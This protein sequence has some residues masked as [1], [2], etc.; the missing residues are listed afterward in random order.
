MYEIRISSNIESIRQKINRIN[1]LLVEAQPI[2]DEIEREGVQ[3]SEE[4][5][6]DEHQD[7]LLFQCEQ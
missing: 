1:K 4:T 6:T 7:I 3:I 5:I 2:A